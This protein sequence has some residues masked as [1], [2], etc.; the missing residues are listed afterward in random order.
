MFYTTDIL[1]RIL[2]AVLVGGLVGANRDLHG[3]PS[4][5]RVHALVSLGAALVTLASTQLGSDGSNQD[6]ISRVIQGI[7]GGIGFLGAGVILRGEN[8]L[9]VYHVATAASIWVT[10]ALGILCGL[11]LW[12]IAII[13]VL[14]VVII[15]VM[16]NKIDRS[17]RGRWDHG[18]SDKL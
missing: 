4:G 10:A 17:L 3:K 7:V 14:A 16:G 5:V 13:G 12:N 6:A 11:G 9:R 8:G 1:C 18:E 2:L 15:L